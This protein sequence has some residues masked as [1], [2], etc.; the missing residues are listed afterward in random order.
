MRVVDEFVRQE[1]VQQGLDRR[2][3]RRGLEQVLAL[4]AHHVLVGERG[5]RAQLAQ[6]VEAH[7]RQP[8]RL[9]RRHVRSPSL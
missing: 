8:R 5:A 3:R 1:G 9:D 7:R 6:T 2:V 4:D